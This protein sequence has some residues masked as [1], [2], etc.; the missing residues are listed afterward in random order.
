MPS[1]VFCAARRVVSHSKSK[2]KPLPNARLGKETPLQLPRSTRVLRVILAFAALA[3]GALLGSAV[4]PLAQP[5]GRIG[6]VEGFPPMCDGTIEDTN[7]TVRLLISV[8]WGENDAD[9]N[10]FPFWLR[11][12]ERA[13]RLP[14]AVVV[15]VGNAEFAA[16]LARSAADAGLAGPHLLFSPPTPRVGGADGYKL[17]SSL[18]AAHVSNMRAAEATGVAFSHALPLA[19]NSLWLRSFDAPMLQQFYSH[20]AHPVTVLPSG[21]PYGMW[22][23]GRFILPDAG[24]W[25]WRANLS[26]TAG[27]ECINLQGACAT[28]AS[29]CAIDSCSLVRMRMWEGLLAPMNVWMRVLVPSAESFLRSD[30][31]HTYPAEEVI[32]ATTVAVARSACPWLRNSFVMSSYIEWTQLEA[33]QDVDY[34]SIHALR[35]LGNKAPLTVKR[36]PRNASNILTQFVGTYTEGGGTFQFPGRPDWGFRP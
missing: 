1:F 23:W 28:N 18:L 32:L 34:Y 12:T 11:A 8:T 35:A 13:V 6:E 21:A 2:S 10:Y 26:T 4:H 31:F 17:G 22:F 5:L 7:A 15:N 20:H 27:E 19:S 33:A 24:L 30:H 29:V 14:Y 16:D 25:S 36:V 9:P 3:F